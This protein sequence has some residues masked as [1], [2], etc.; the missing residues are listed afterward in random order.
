MKGPRDD[1]YSDGRRLARQAAGWLALGLLTGW[2]MSFALPWPLRAVGALVLVGCAAGLFFSSS[3]LLTRHHPVV[4]VFG[5]RVWYRGLR[6]QV[7]M[8]RRVAQARHVRIGRFALQ[9]PAIELELLDD[10]E[11]LRLPLVA[12]DCDPDQLVALIMQRVQA[13]QHDRGADD[14]EVA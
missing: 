8:L 11:L 4:S 6:E 9:V 1:F 7:V 2:G 14:A 10:D 3:R 5:D 12:L 13:L